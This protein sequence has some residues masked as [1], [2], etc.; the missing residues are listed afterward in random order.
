MMKKTLRQKKIAIAIASL[1]FGANTYAGRTGDLEVYAPADGDNSPTLMFMVET[2]TFMWAKDVDLKWDPKTWI[3]ATEKEEVN[4]DSYHGIKYNRWSYAT[5]GAGN[6]YSR[7]SRLKDTI[8]YLMNTPGA[9][10]DDFKI[11][12][13][14]Y[15]ATPVGSRTQTNYKTGQLNS[16]SGGIFIP[17]KPIGGDPERCSK[18]DKTVP[19]NKCGM[20]SDHRK[21]IKEFIASVCNQADDCAGET[22]MAW[23]YAEAGAYMMGTKTAPLATLQGSVEDGKST[24]ENALPTIFS[25]DSVRLRGR[26]RISTQDATGITLNKQWQICPE[27]KQVLVDYYTNAAPLNH[28][29]RLDCKEED[30]ITI[31]KETAKN[32]TFGGN[33]LEWNSILANRP[34]GIAG[35]HPGWGRPARLHFTLDLSA[36]I[37]RNASRKRGTPYWNYFIDRLNRPN[38]PIPSRHGIAGS[39][40]GSGIRNSPIEVRDDKSYK[41]KDANISECSTVIA[42]ADGNNQKE[43]GAKNGIIFFTSGFNRSATA[44]L[45]TNVNSKYNSKRNSAENVMN[46]SLS[47]FESVKIDAVGGDVNC[48]SGLP[49]SGAG[50]PINNNWNCIGGYAKRLNSTDNPIAK[51]LKTSVVLFSKT[52]EMVSD[53]SKC[54]T[55]DVPASVLNACLLGSEKYGGG[56]F[57]QTTQAL[58]DKAN[59]ELVTLINGYATSEDSKI[60]VVDSDMPAVPANP[61]VPGALLPT[62]YV[63]LIKPNVGTKAAQWQG[64]V[65]KY[66]ADAGVFKDKKD[67]KLFDK[68]VMLPTTLDLWSALDTAYETSKQKGGV[69]EKTPYF[70]KNETDATLIPTR[71][72]YINDTN[73]SSLKKVT[74][75]ATVLKGISIKNITS[76]GTTDATGT[77]TTIQNDLRRRL[78][79]FMGY[80]IGTF[81]DT[82]TTDEQI[83]ATANAE[84][85]RNMGGVV[86]STPLYVSHKAKIKNDGDIEIKE[87]SVIFGAMDNAL[88]V[89]DAKTGKEKFAFIPKEALQGKI[90]DKEENYKALTKDGTWVD[91]PAF[92]VDA[93]WI[94]D[95]KYDYDFTNKDAADKDKDRTIKAKSVDI[96]GGLRL[97]G[98]SYYKLDITNLDSPKLKFR[99][100]P[101]KTDFKRMGYT[102]AKPVIT[103]IKW[104]GKRTK[105]MIVPGG[106]DRSYDRTD[107]KRKADK[108]TQTMGNAVYIVRAEGK[109]KADGSID[110]TDIGKKIMV[111]GKST[112]EGATITNANMDFSIVGAV[113]T[114]D[115]DADG[116]TDHVYFADLAGQ[117]FRLDINNN[118]FTSTANASATRVTRIADLTGAHGTTNP[119][120]RFYETPLVTIHKN[121]VQRFA[122]VSVASGD[123]SNP[124]FKNGDND[125]TFVGYTDNV[126]AIIDKDVTREDLFKDNITLNTENITKDKLKAN[127]TVADQG[128]L[129]STINNDERLDGWYK[130]LNQYG[131]KTSVK[132]LKA[133]GPLAAIQNDLYVGVYNY[134][135]K[136]VDY[137]SCKNEVRG[138]T[139][140]NMFCLPYGY[141]STTTTNNRKAFKIGKGLMP[142]AFGSTDEKGLNR[143]VLTKYN[144]DGTTGGTDGNSTTKPIYGFNYEMKPTRWFELQKNIQQQEESQGGTD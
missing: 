121:G 45:P 19:A 140:A 15:Q 92:G 61:Y 67:K 79:N 60:G 23:A 96:Y 90:G 5:W 129:L 72:V 134:Y 71:N 53:K 27:D 112:S 13:G 75:S 54:N 142:V 64:N 38:N 51:K 84:A 115:R 42:D 123:R 119:G 135:D 11:G 87:E 68:G 83:S 73:D 62:G 93:P 126:Y 105:V 31:T 17:A 36:T 1:L 14:R 86:H 10:P 33:Q 116:L 7:I 40:M 94:A 24:K 110:E 77:N 102:F 35:E 48:N 99:I 18:L 44:P 101:D 49:T 74:G 65:R 16:N 141:C 57:I 117:V 66:K 131:A 107:A 95:V 85:S 138:E 139:E 59:E 8:F 128:N 26:N 50:N 88:H 132:H 4:D 124:N 3:K 56:G 89:V 125:G 103:H 109:L 46:M 133:M 80:T 58:A 114:L 6:K 137:T 82:T 47:P 30:W 108:N 120:P 127:P 81:D 2:S 25:F 130:P 70:T 143:T 9:I 78:L 91:G 100:G 21:L 43:I 52:D 122:V 144:S 55:K 22:P 12:V 69:Y 98:T 37:L 76:G 104:D 28:N 34:H 111:V 97:G 136:G 32:Y 63:P 113:K 20:Y 106:Y 41:Y 39:F 29:Y 118:V